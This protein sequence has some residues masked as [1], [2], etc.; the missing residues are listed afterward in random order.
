[1]YYAYEEYLEE[2]LFDGGNEDD[3]L[4]VLQAFPDVSSHLESDCLLSVHERCA[5]HT[6]HLIVSTD[7]KQARFKN[8]DFK[9]DLKI[10]FTRKCR[11]RP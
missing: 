7:F 9:Q 6:L 2:A 5:T 3:S 1:M 10:L 8:T 11:M 4:R